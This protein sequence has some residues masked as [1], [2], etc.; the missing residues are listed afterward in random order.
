M[1]SVVG[2]DK[3]ACGYSEDVKGGGR[4]KNTDCPPLFYTRRLRVKLTRSSFTMYATKKCYCFS[5]A[6]CSNIIELSI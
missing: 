4:R 1:E 2:L 5:S 3:T 6:L